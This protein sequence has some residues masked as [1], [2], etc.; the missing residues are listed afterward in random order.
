MAWHRKTAAGPILRSTGAVLL[1]L[2]SLAARHLFR[3]PIAAP[4]AI[5]AGIAAL[6]FVS[7]SAGSALTALG[8]HLFDRV[9]VS[10]RW[11]RR[12]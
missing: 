9:A 8:P 3:V 11:Q 5:D 7:A 2:A 6:L 4:G 1:G 12:C 10:P